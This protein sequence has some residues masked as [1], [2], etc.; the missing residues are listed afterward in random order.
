MGETKKHIVEVAEIIYIIIYLPM[1]TRR[2][3]DC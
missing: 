1:V 2:E 3:I